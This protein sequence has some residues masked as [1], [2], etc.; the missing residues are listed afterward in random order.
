[1]APGKVGLTTI[2]QGPAPV[3]VAFVTPWYGEFA[4]GAEVAVRQ[5]A[6]SLRAA[7][8]DVEVLTTCVRS[9]FHSW[10]KDDYR[11][12]KYE[13]N[14][15][16]VRR[17]RVNTSGRPLFREVS[18]KIL[19]SP[20]I[21][22]EDELKYLRGSIASDS[23]VDHIARHKDE[24]VFVLCPYLYGLTYWA[25]RA[26]PD[27]SIVLPCLH[28][29]PQA[30]F[31][32]TRELLGARKV[33]FLSPEEMSLAKRLGGSSDGNFTIIGSGVSGPDS[34]RPERFREKYG[35]KGPYILYVGRKDLGKNILTLVDYFDEYKRTDESGLQLLFLGGGD[36]GQV[37]RREHFVDLGYVDDDD[38]NDAYAGALCTCLLSENESFSLVIMESWLASRP[39]IVSDRCP[40][41]KGHCIRSNG[42]LFVADEHEF[43]GAIQF[44]GEHPDKASLM[45]KNGR[46]YVLGNYDREEIVRKFIGIVR[47]FE[48]RDP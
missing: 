16:T 23:L 22:R 4:G 27:R 18:E 7:G 34:Y 42:G 38:K 10:W 17:F 35:I 47:D 24:F 21:T 3:K 33:L 5:L 37:P 25:Y 48:V 11:P 26:A 28:D 46:K 19:L 1:M 8:M 36:K 43:A 39:V 31:S 20:V 45:G 40:V 15:V 9:P 41:T 6:E 32:T 29:E 44:L 14:G 30:R 12:G 2:T 13:L